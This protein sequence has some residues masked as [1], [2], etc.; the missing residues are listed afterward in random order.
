MEKRSED[1]PQFRGWESEVDSAKEHE[2]QPMRRAGFQE[3]VGHLKPTEGN[4][5]GEHDQQCEKIQ[6]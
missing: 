6:D 5:G 4:W 2:K 3:K 1:T